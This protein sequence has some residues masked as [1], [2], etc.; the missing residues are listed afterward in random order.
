MN[1]A[2]T[3]PWYKMT[4]RRNRFRCHDASTDAYLQWGGNDLAM[5][6]TIVIR[7]FRNKVV[8]TVNGRCTKSFQR[9]Q[10]HNNEP[11][12]GASLK[13]VT[14]TATTTTTKWSHPTLFYRSIYGRNR[15]I[16]A[17]CATM[18]IHD[19]RWVH[20]P[21]LSSIMTGSTTTTQSQ[22]SS[23]SSLLSQ[24]TNVQFYHQQLQMQRMM[25]ESGAVD[26]VRYSLYA[27][28]CSILAPVVPTSLCTPWQRQRHTDS[29]LPT[30]TS[31]WWRQSW[32]AA[33]P[34]YIFI[35]CDT[36]TTY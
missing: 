3:V 36:T 4:R 35:G 17:V 25:A 13:F 16:G 10:C 14:T 34:H 9:Q 21:T 12:F 29:T 27:P 22:S 26:K 33:L 7:C 1:T 18:C 2:R 11:S 32:Y 5:A 31:I 23:L 24:A 20:P 30:N 6:C 15:T 28:V 19:P 8:I